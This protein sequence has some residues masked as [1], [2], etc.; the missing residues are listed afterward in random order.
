MDVHSAS[1][2][3]FE[4]ETVAAQQL[5]VA[6]LVLNL[7]VSPTPNRMSATCKQG[8]SAR[9]KAHHQRAPVMLL[10]IKEWLQG[11]MHAGADLNHFAIEFRSEIDALRCAIFCNVAPPLVCQF[12]GCLLDDKEFLLNSHCHCV[13]GFSVGHRRLPWWRFVG[14][15]CRVRSARGALLSSHPPVEHRVVAKVANAS[16]KIAQARVPKRQRLR[17]G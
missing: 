5:M 13:G 2:R 16:E 8:F 7:C 6:L 17:E 1:Q 14:T 9:P 15:M 10:L 3:A 12:A 4:A 11:G